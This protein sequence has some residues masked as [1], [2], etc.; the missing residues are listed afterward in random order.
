[1]STAEFP[2][3]AK[4][5]S[6]DCIDVR[7]VFHAIWRHPLAFLGLLLLASLPAAGVLYFSPLPKPSA[8]VV[9]HISSPPQVPIGAPALIKNRRT[10]NAALKEPEVRNLEIIRSAQ[11]DALTWLDKSLLV[12]ARNGMNG[13]SECMRVSIDGENGEELIALLT[14]VSKAY[15]T[16]ADDLNN[17]ARDRRL[18]FL[19]K[20]HAKAKDELK[21]LQA[22][23]DE[24]A[25]AL[26]T[27]DGAMLAIL[28]GFNNDSLRLA[29]R[30]HGK[31]KDELEVVGL[32]LSS[33]KSV[34]A[35]RKRTAIM[36]VTG[37]VWAATLPQREQLSPLVI[38][39]QFTIPEA[40]I[41]EEARQVLVSEL[42]MAVERARKVLTDIETLLPPGSNAPQLLNARAALKTAEEKR[43]KYNEKFAHNEETRL[44][45]IEAAYNMTV[46]RI[47]LARSKVAK[48][49]QEISKL[50]TYRID[51][52]NKRA[53]IAQKEKVT[54]LMADEIER[55]KIGGRAPPRVTVW[56]EPFLA[57]T[58]EENRRLHYALFSGLALFLAGFC[59]LVGWEYC[60]RR[61]TP[62]STTPS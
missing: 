38:H 15:R 31:Q 30:E 51:L 1:M 55:L 11:P 23:I 35:W 27:K 39:H 54:A 25:V 9:F 50:N 19:E 58:V 28:D 49:E 43:D 14:A 5:K 62:S 26:G 42:N 37:G 17:E 45:S 61:A 47:E 4:T 24:I 10:L 34:S 7:V 3:D 60:N 12:D 44:A 18:D 32:N 33:M 57:E 22:Q 56:E 21:K 2:T 16:A 6:C 40:A 59:G 48:L 46:A 36:A 53:E 8:A 20:S 13:I 29:L 41:E 52:E